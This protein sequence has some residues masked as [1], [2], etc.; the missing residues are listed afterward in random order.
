MV[1]F[2]LE[3]LVL[4]LVSSVSWMVLVGIAGFVLYRIRKLSQ[5]L[6]T[7]KTLEDIEQEE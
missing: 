4:L 3:F 2:D 6:K 7:L 5:E 1:N